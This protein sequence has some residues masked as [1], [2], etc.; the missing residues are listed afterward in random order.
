MAVSPRQAA[1]ARQA[2]SRT[3]ARSYGAA[4]CARAAGSSLAVWLSSSSESCSWRSSAARQVLVVQRSAASARRSQTVLQLTAH[5]SES[6]TTWAGLALLSAVCALLRVPSSC[7]ARHI[8]PSRQ[9]GMSTGGTGGGIGTAINGM[10]THVGGTRGPS[11]LTGIL[12]RRRLSPLVRSLID[13]TSAA[14]P[15]VA[16]NG[17]PGSWQRATGNGRSG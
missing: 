3:A 5:S 9:A 13:E 7:L 10:R 4:S 11:L 16:G 17:K 15:E 12:A 14:G 1:R 2:A 8:N 6:S